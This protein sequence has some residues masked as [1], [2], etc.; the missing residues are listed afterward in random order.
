MSSIVTVTTAAT[1]RN[2]ATL[3]NARMA[4]G[5]VASDNSDDARLNALLP[6][7]SAACENYCQRI[8]AQETVSELFR[9]STPTRLAEPPIYAT[10]VALARWPVTQIV[11]VTLDGT[12]LAASDYELDG[13]GGFLYRLSSDART[14]WRGRKLVVNYVAGYRLPDQS[15]R[16]LPQEIE[17][18]CLE[19]LKALHGGLGRDPALRSESVEG[20]GS[21][22][23]ADAVTQ[24]ALPPMAAQLLQPYRRIEI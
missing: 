13:M 15:T 10:H 14:Y 20:V 24:A 9:D 4:I 11:S 22:S 21:A 3:A 18:A 1:V 2:L 12:A 19:V 17:S 16:T 5:L 8:F 7:A 23:Y 6:L